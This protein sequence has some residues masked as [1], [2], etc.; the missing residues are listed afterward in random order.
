MCTSIVL[1]GHSLT[2]AQIAAVACENMSVEVDW[3]AIERASAA[4]A[5]VLELAGSSDKPIYGLNVGLGANKD[6]HIS[7]EMYHSFNTRILRSHGVALPPMASRDVVRATMLCR[8]NGLLTGMAGVDVKIIYLLRDMLNHQIHPQIPERGSVGMSDLGNMAYMALPLI[9]E[10]YVEFHGDI[11]PA[12]EALRLCGLSPVQLG[13][14]DGLPL[15]SSNAFSVAKAALLCEDINML[16]YMADAV[17]ATGYEALGYN[18]MFLDMRGLPVRPLEGHRQSLTYVHACLSGSKLWSSGNNSL[19][20]ALSYK[21]GCSI[22][23][24]VWDSLKYVQ[25]LLPTYINSS[26]DCPMVLTQE[27]EIISTDH[28]II[29]GLAVAFEMLDIALAHLSKTICNRILRLGNERFSGLPRFLRP[30]QDVIAYATI[31]K[32][33]SALDGEIRHLAN[34]ASLDYLPTANESEDHGCNTPYVMGKT[35]QIVDLLRYL[36]GIEAMHSAQAADLAGGRPS[37]QGT[38]YVYDCVR[39]AIPFLDQDNRD[40]GADMQR[41][42]QLVLEK[43]L[44]YQEETSHA[45]G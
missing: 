13:P 16:L 38:G 9:G 36:I 28:F 39:Q 17:F 21:S 26:D 6:V 32:T 43:K 12:A 10:G 4:R 3:P 2:T 5:V 23:G 24:A 11:L 33:V 14:K 42:Y 45:E 41:A 40:L 27:R 37:G 22:H 19:E 35:E 7:P 15:V 30:E 29:T 34:P 44:L 31:Q 20:G 18:P 1:D 8:L 25:T